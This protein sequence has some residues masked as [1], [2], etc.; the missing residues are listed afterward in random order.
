MLGDEELTYKIRSCVFEVYRELG[1]GFLEK[2]YENAL[3][4]ELLKH[5]LDVKK[6]FPLRVNYKENIIRRVYD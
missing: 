3:E 5:E 1:S 2:V 6:Q 4:I